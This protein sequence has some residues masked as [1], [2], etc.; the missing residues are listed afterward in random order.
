MLKRFS[1]YYRG[2]LPL[3]FL[4]FGCAFLMAGMDLVFPMVV[5]QMVDDLLPQ[6]NL[7]VILWAGLGLFLLYIVRALLNYIVD[8]YGHVLGVRMEYDMRKDLFIATVTLLGSFIILLTIHWPLALIVFSVI[9]LMLWF[10]ISKNKEM[11][12]SFRDMRLKV[13]DINARVEDSISG[14]RVVKSFTNE[15]YEKEKFEEGNANFR[16]SREN[17]FQVMG[18]FFQVLTFFPI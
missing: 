9:P 16:K 17:A 1:K 14:V 6:K 7:T 2:H 15:W 13:A 8:Y 12:K 18:Q 10:A 5:R 4:D 11:Q 3:F